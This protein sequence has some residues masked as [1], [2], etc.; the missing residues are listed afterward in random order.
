M[1][2]ALMI[3]AILM[4]GCAGRSL[5]PICHAPSGDLFNGQI[6]QETG[7]VCVGKE[8]KRFWWAEQF[9]YAKKRGCRLEDSCGIFPPYYINAEYC[10]EPQTICPGQH[11]KPGV[12]R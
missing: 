6:D 11:W 7:L 5:A 9:E 3:S 8:W 12:K 1:K 2:L 10:G 4:S